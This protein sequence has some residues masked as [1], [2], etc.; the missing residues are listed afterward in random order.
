M[1]VDE[2]LRSSHPDVFAAGDV[3]N[4]YHPALGRHVRVEH[5]DN[6]IQQGRAAAAA[7]SAPSAATT[8]CRTSSPTS[9]TSAWSTSAAPRPDGYDEVVLRGDLAAGSSRRSGSHGGR[10]VAGMQAND[11]DATAD[12]RRIVTA[13]E[14]D[15]DALRDTQNPLAD[16][17]P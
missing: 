9:T 13:G 8:G 5:W 2:H 6:A 15:L 7:C 10:V 17:A 4:A 11:W 14:V 16:V 3:A 1:V 12:I